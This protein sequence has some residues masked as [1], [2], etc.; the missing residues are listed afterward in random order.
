MPP[1]PVPAGALR[2]GFAGTPPFAAAA[3]QAIADA[4]YALPLV[5]TQPDRPA[6]RGLALTPSA[7][8]SLAL[9]RGLPL[10]Q[11]RGLRLDGRWAAD[12][13]AARQTLQAARLD[14]LVVAAYGLILPD[15]VLA[16]P[17]L[18]CLNLHASLL[19]RWRGAAP[20]ARA[21]EADDQRTGITVMQMDAGLDT[22]PVLS[23]H[24]LTIAADDTTG[25]L[26]ERLAALGAGA[27]VATLQAL[28]RG[29][30]PA[31][32]Q[33]VEGVSYAV[34]VGKA[35]AVLDWRDPAELIERRVRAF[36]PAPG[37][38]FTAAGEVV[39]LWRAALWPRSD[40][41]APG[42]ILQPES[43]RLVVAC[44]RGAL[45]LLEVQRPG[46]RRQAAAALAARLAARGDTVLPLAADAPSS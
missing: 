13:D 33:P 28:Q 26:T 42:T 25:S 3:L 17:R 35:E 44:G 4:G 37:A 31:V 21:I 46:G 45:E 8:K 36:D 12:A 16:L 23:L 29:P 40:G 14:L 34:K 19:P 39:K 32:P 9:A 27:I 18:G 10:A 5:L 1:E 22:G 15:W 24:P 30:L 7:V 38:R 20:I 41:A 6:G 2:V 43:G 11:P